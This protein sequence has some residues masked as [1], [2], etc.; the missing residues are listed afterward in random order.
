[1]AHLVERSTGSVAWHVLPDWQSTLLGPTGLPMGELRRVMEVGHEAGLLR[2]SQRGLALGLFAVADRPVGGFVTP[3]QQLPRARADMSKADVLRLASR[4]RVSLV[5]VESP[6]RPGDLLGY[7]RV[8]DLGLSPGEA[9]G[10]WRELMAISDD[11]LQLAALIRMQ[12]AEQG[13]ARVVGADGKTIGV[14]TVDQ[15]REP[16]LLSG[17][18]V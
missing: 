3:L 8:I 16:L 14:V 11:T 17:G 10:P 5:P 18:P 1:M 9:L 12:T 7:Y 2:R 13:L 15:L 4:Y 6:D